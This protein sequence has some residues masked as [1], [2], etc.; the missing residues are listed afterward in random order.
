MGGTNL[1]ALAIFLLLLIDYP[2]T[3]VDFVRF[4]KPW[5]HA[6]DL[7][8]GFFRMFERSITIVQDTDSIPKFGF[9]LENKMC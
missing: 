6:H 2:K 3:E 4:F 7:G 5:F 9:L 1:Q 8:K